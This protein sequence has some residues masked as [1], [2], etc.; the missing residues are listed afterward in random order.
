V[1]PLVV[2]EV[3]LTARIQSVVDRLLPA[4][5]RTPRVTGRGDLDDQDLATEVLKLELSRADRQPLERKQARATV[6]GA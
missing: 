6:S 2:V 5:R 4:A 3:A 1:R